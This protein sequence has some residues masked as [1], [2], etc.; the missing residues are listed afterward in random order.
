VKL[1]AQPH[2]APGI[3]LAVYCGN[4]PIAIHYLPHGLGLR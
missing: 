1:P 2:I 3:C 4:F